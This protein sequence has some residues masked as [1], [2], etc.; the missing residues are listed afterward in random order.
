MSDVDQVQKSQP[1][2]SQSHDDVIAQFKWQGK[3][4][5]WLLQWLVKFV[6]NTKVEMG[7]TLSVG[8]N[9]VS[10][11]L[12]SHDTYFEQLADDISAP[13]SSFAN[14]TDATMKEMILSFKPGESSEDTPAFHFI[15]LKDCRTYST[16]GNP[17]CDAGVLWRG[18]ISA[19]DGF[20]IGLIAEKPDAA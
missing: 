3:Q 19:V 13:F 14:G 18:R 17:I 5:D 4:I 8:G 15:H 16:D 2:P 9:L 10:G 6:A 11:H 1:S 12:I 20:T 7:V